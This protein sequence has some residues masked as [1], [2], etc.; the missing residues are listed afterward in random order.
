[1]RQR[2]RRALGAALAVVGPAGF[3]ISNA[4]G[5][6]IV[7]L[8][9]QPDRDAAFQ[10]ALA[11]TGDTV[12]GTV[13]T[14]GFVL[15]IVAQ[16]GML[17]VIIG[18]VRV[19]LVNAWVLPLPVLGIAVNAVVGTMAATLVADLLRLAAG[20]WIAIGL[21]RGNRAQWLGAAPPPAAQ[22]RRARAA[23]VDIA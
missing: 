23:A 14:V 10:T 4:T 18:L 17:L 9:Q 12:L 6:T 13:G 22:G 15:E 21:A 19:R 5:L 2:Y 11:V 1:M 20:T 16:L 8:A 3:S 7:A